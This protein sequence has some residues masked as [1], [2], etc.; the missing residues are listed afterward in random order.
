MR[1]LYPFRSLIMPVLLLATTLPMSGQDTSN[2]QYLRAFSTL[3]KVESVSKKEAATRFAADHNIPVRISNG[4]QQSELMSISKSG[5]PQYYTITNVNSARTISTSKVSGLSGKGIQSDGSGIEIY[6]WDGGAVMGTHQ[7]LEGR[8]VP[9]DSSEV[10]FHATH[11]AGTMIAAGV[12]GNARGMAP[13]ATIKSYEW[14]NDAGEMAEAAANGALLSNHSYGLLRGWSYNGTQWQWYGDT[15]VSKAEDYLFGFYDEQARDWDQIAYSA[16]WYLVVKSA[17]NDAG[18][19]PQGATFPKDG[20]YDCI[21][22][23]AVAKN[24]LTVGAVDDI[25][26]GFSQAC[27]VIAA[28]FSSCGPVDDG[29]IK[30]DV[31]TN[32]VGLY[33]AD[34]KNDAS[35]VTLSGT[36]M[37]AAS[38]TG[39]IAV[40]QG[41]FYRLKGHY[42]KSATMK[43]LVIHTA[44]E[45]GSTP[46]PDYRFGW[47]L[48]NTYSAASKIAEDSSSSVIIEESISENETYQQAIV[49]N[50][51]EPLKVTVVWTDA[52]G[53]PVAP[54]LDPTNAML[55]N[56]LDL[57]ITRDGSTWFP[58]K[59]DP[60]FPSA[61]ATCNSPNDVDNVEQVSIEAPDSGIY[62]ITVSHRGAL[63]GGAQE[64]SMLVSGTGQKTEPQTDPGSNP[65]TRTTMNTS[66][67]VYPNPAFSRITLETETSS[68]SEVL[69]Y[70]TLGQLV[71]KTMSTDYQ[72]EMEISDLDPGLY[73]I[74]VKTGNT[75]SYTKLYK[76]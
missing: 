6:Q 48:M 13:G 31:V 26:G 23:G 67:Q 29:R 70:N 45:A 59:L 32:G 44:D 21:S 63:T 1:K 41:L 11:V 68:P 53:T 71:K 51:K 33:S 7:E 61:A 14:N 58:W 54:S 3:R 69:F 38:A 37:S 73:V 57:K 52:P 34:D 24:V 64:F 17:G 76:E 22:N 8:V 47:G 62:M 25:P 72:T 4:N 60:A 27:N 42:M 9:G 56:N 20:P 43:G 40:L 18:E 39:S 35:Y 49:A 2:V 55:V 12:V 5:Q 65:S 15:T 50:G 46:G 16:P 75:Y 10:S 74:L 36:S 28:S 30:P 19:G 66:L